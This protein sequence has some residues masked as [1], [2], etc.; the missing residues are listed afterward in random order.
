MHITYTRLILKP[1]A[2]EETADEE[3][4]WFVVFGLQSISLHP[5][6]RYQMHEQRQE[7]QEEE[8]EEDEERETKTDRHQMLQLHLKQKEERN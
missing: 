3:S 6:R 8:D 5:S 4:F 2:K 1:K 7:L